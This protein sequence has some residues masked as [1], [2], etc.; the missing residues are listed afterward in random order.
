METSTPQPVTAAAPGYHVQELPGSGLII[1]LKLELVDRVLA[2]VM[3]GFGAV[4]RR[5]AEVGGMLIGR[6]EVGSRTT[7]W[8]EDFEAI[9]CQHKRGPSYL[10]SEPDLTLFRSTVE[11]CAA[12]DGKI[13]PVGFYRSHTRDGCSIGEDDRRLC[14]KLFPPPNGIVLIVRPFAAKVSV[15]GFIG[16]EAEL[17]TDWPADTFPFRRLELEGGTPARRKPLS[18]AR[19]R[20]ERALGEDNGSKGNGA[21]RHADDGHSLFPQPVFSFGGYI[22]PGTSDRTGT[23]PVEA[24][25]SRSRL[26][27]WAPLCFLFLAIGIILGFAASR[28]T[29]ATPWALLQADPYQLGLTATRHEKSILIHWNRESSPIRRAS[30]AELVIYEGGLS[31]IVHLRPSELRTGSVIYHSSGA[32][33]LIRLE[34]LVTDHSVVSESISWKP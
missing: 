10:L 2:E 5:G 6:L 32:P 27:I 29:G 11:D 26:W 25:R 28:T 15:G 19:L 21:G 24:R 7:V 16:Y 34:A 17:L 33:A 18:E 22:D 4:P 30:G 13:R 23:V 20:L 9:P 8:I 31:K 1:Q 3:A 12:R 14:A